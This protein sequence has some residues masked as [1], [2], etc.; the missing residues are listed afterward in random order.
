MS[1]MR[2][3]VKV[4]SVGTRGWRWM[5]DQCGQVD[6]RWYATRDRAVF[7]AQEHVRSTHGTSAP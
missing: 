2:E 3:L 6:N 1:T 7:E 4:E 5:C